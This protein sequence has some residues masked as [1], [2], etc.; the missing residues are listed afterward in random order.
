[1]IVGVNGFKLNDPSAA[2]RVYLDEPVEGLSMAP[3]RTSSGNYSGRNGGYVGAQ[4]YGAR[5][6]TFTG[7]VWADDVFGLE[8][9]R[10]AFETAVATGSVLLTITTDA[11]NQYLVYAYLDSLDMPIVRSWRQAPFTL[12]LV[13]PD[14]T[15]YDNSGG[16]NTAAISPVSGGGVVWPIAWNPVKWRPGGLPTSIV[17]SGNV[18]VFPVI[19][20]TGPMTNPTIT[21][22]STNQFFTLQG[23]TTSAGDVVTIDM[24]NRTVLLNGGS[25]LAYLTPTSSW[26]P[27][28]PG[29]N[30]IKL[31]TTNGSDTVTGTFSWRSGFRGI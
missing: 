29:G 19:T 7:R 3:V 20:L 9:T 30:S 4:F 24:Y 5:L 6:I 13:A 25:I 23:L 27:L 15:I 17:N 2:N 16:L 22:V 18:A 28:L 26:F 8:N 10:R 11:G 1:M 12:T 21:N 14:P 31:T